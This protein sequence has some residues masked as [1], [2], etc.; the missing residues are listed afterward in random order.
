MRRFFLAGAV[1][2]LLLTAGTASADYLLLKVRI[3]PTIPNVT[4]GGANPNLPPG[5][6]GGMVGTPGAPGVPQGPPG[7]FVG[8]S[9]G[10][11]SGSTPSPGG[12][13]Q[14]GGPRPGGFGQ[15]GGPRPGGFGRFG[16]QPGA[17]SGP[18]APGMPAT[19]AGPQAPGVPGQ[20]GVPG[21]QEPPPPDEKPGDYLYAYLEVNKV[22]AGNGV[23][24]L[25]HFAW[26]KRGVLLAIPDFVSFDLIQAKTFP[27]RFD[28]EFKGLKES[29][30]GKRKAG[31][32][33]SL[34]RLANLALSHRL[35]K[36]FRQAMDELARIDAKSDPAVK[37]LQPLIANYQ[38]AQ[39]ELKKTLPEDDPAV[40]PLVAE[41][42]GEGYKPYLSDGGH[43]VLYTK[44]AATPATKALVE[45]KLARL[46]ETFESFYYWFALQR[47]ATQ[48]A[49]PTHRLAVVLSDP[50]SF[51]NRYVSWG[52]PP[53]VGDGFTP[54]GANVLFI[55]SKRQDAPYSKFEAA[56]KEPL[57]KIL[58]KF[59]EA[60]VTRDAIL[61]G[62]IWDDKQRA[63]AMG[64]YIM[65][66]QTMLLVEK[67][68]EDDAERATLTHD[69]TRQLL[70]GSGLFPRNVNV[71]E[72]VLSGLSSYFDTPALAVY[73]GVGLPSWTELINFKY[74]Q[75]EKSGKLN[76]PTDV[77]YSV[78]TDR[79]FQQAQQASELARDQ[80]EDEKLADRARDAW[81]LARSTAWAFVYYLASTGRVNDLIQYGK[82][83][84]DL[85]RDLDLGELALQACAARAFKLGDAKNAGRLDLN[86]RGKELAA[87]WFTEM[88]N[89]IL[90]LST[91]EDFHLRMR[92][93]L[94][95]PRRPP[96][97]ATTPVGPPGYGPPGAPP[98]PPQSPQ[99]NPNNN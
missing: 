94:S 92:T 32:A 93:E 74:F 55:A 43:Y 68:L 85:P 15:Y 37:E 36:Q 41:L 53:A 13:G 83:M 72:W 30:D 18:Q 77:L 51:Q 1:A 69:G 45:H 57:A 47:G 29:K 87:A 12:F 64:P 86:G 59:S 20:P 63:A 42:G 62:K 39:K 91:V 26:G 23:A 61:S 99:F 97:A 75:K 25:E 79:Y 17:P 89:V 66:G 46:E 52:M 7:T 54:Q 6:P 90:D 27:K 8:G 2:A 71:P 49:L 96:P 9:T 88:R 67:A 34:F 70:V 78:L 14:Y 38:R 4:G 82:E 21:A 24:N 40:R 19:P 73:P 11:A 16:G 22:L 50:G 33:E 28:E 95:Q 10:P 31:A 76:N 48:P 98:R 80:P 84:N 56:L 81:D 44:F 65:L 3:E 5:A 60:G 35:L 58:T